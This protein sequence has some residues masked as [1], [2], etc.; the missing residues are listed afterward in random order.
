[1]ILKVLAR[2]GSLHGYA[3]A[4]RIQ[5]ATDECRRRFHF[6]CFTTYPA[7]LVTS[8]APHSVYPQLEAMDGRWAVPSQ[9]VPQYLLLFAAAQL[10]PGCAH[11][12]VCFSDIAILSPSASGHQHTPTT[13]KNNP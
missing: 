11:F 9:Y 5:Q 12:G 10:Q 13:P 2:S 1:L 3:I 6:G 8:P 4:Q 7:V